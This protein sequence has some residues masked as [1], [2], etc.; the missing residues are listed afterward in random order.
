MP[1]LHDQIRRRLPIGT[2]PTTAPAAVVARVAAL[3]VENRSEPINA[4][5]RI[6]RRRKLR[7]EHRIPGIEL[8]LLGCRELPPRVRQMSVVLDV[9]AQNNQRGGERDEFQFG[10]C[11][12]EDAA[13]GVIE[14][15]TDRSVEPLNCSTRSLLAGN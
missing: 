7:I 5:R 1:E 4:P 9:G 6:V 8:R 14:A 13:A 2:G 15:T 10:A 12:A 3:R 11:A